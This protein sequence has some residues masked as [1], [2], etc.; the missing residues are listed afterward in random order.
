[1]VEA[2]GDVLVGLPGLDGAEIAGSAEVH[3][4][5]ARRGLQ[6]IGDPMFFFDQ[7]PFDEGIAEY[8]HAFG[9]R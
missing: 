7:E 9:G 6:E 1:V 4:L 3:K 5:H 2:R 8:D